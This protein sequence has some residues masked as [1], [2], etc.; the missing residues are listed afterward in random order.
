MPT[1]ECVI[2]HVS[3]PS[4]ESTVILEAP[5]QGDA[6]TENFKQNPGTFVKAIREISSSD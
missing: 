1:Y 2:A 4:E 6:L 5:S 3:N